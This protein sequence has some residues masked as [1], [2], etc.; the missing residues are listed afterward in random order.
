MDFPAQFA[1]CLEMRVRRLCPGSWGSMTGQEQGT[2]RGLIMPLEQS[3]AN[4]SS[5][6]KP[7]CFCK[8]ELVRTQLCSLFTRCLWLLLCWVAVTEP[9]GPQSQEH[10]LSGLYRKTLLPPA[11]E[12][13]HALQNHQSHILFSWSIV[14]GVFAPKPS[15][16]L[17]AGLFLPSALHCIVKP[18]S[19]E[20]FPT[21]SFMS[22]SFFI[23]LFVYLCIWHQ[24]QHFPLFLICSIFF[25]T[26]IFCVLISAN[27]CSN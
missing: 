16:A 24:K 5:Q 23:Y 1:F 8:Q 13:S 19:Y 17:W 9:Y 20:G 15:L 10:S 18:F 7:R 26:L 2:S 14:P 4:H 22:T 6:P 25:S 12:V 3:L 27:F 11:L 21:S